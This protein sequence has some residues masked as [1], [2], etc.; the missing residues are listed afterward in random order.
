MASNQKRVVVTGIGLIS[1]LG[2]D[3]ETFFSNLIAGKSGIKRVTRFDPTDYTSQIGAQVDDFDPVKWMDFKVAKNNDRYAQFAVA[4]S[5]SAVE[6]AKLNISA[7]DPFRV[8]VLMGSGIGGMETIEI[9]SKRLFD[10][11]PRKVSPF[12]IPSLIANMA[13]GLVGIELGAKGP[14]FAIVSAC[15]TGSHSIGESLRI[16]RSGDADVMIAGGTEAAIT[17]LAYSGFC[18]MKA[19]STGFNETP[20]LASR[21]FDKRRDGFVMGEGAA[22]LVLETLEHAQARSATPLCEVVAYSATCD[23]YHV[24]S[25]DPEGQG[26]AYCLRDVLKKA[27]IP[28]EAVGYIN[29]HGTSTAYNDKFET[30]A[31]K[32]VFKEHARALKISSTKSMT[33]H[34]LGAAGG[35]EA[36][37]VAKA[38]QTGT[39]PPT[40]NYEE[41]DPECDLDYIPN[42]FQKKEVEY[43][44]SSNLGF[45]GQNACLLMRRYIP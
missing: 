24:T 26:L 29:A 32:S 4:A 2:S 21:P 39:L 25:P 5:R 16:L 36:A 12:T 6:S 11:G 9:Q 17:R 44:I 7:M 1:A 8:G 13:S 20:E 34:L 10:L 15:A 23:A 41:A 14:N 27:D 3:V 31:I 38:L 40:I 28:P 18:S 45:G 30:L 35:I 43:A 19:M 33:G 22:T 42:A 37:A